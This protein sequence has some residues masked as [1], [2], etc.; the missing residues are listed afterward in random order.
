MKTHP[1]KI[2]K[3]TGTLKELARDIAD[4]RYDVLNDFLNQLSI[5]IYRD[6]DNDYKRGRNLLSSKLNN[7]ACIV[8]EASKEVEKVWNIC[9]KYMPKIIKEKTKK[10]SLSLRNIK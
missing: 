1:I 8:L 3:Y 2:E 10:D 6:S 7:I 9:E 5:C 4:L